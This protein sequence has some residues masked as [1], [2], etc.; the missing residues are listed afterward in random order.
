MSGVDNDNEV[1]EEEYS[2]AP[3]GQTGLPGHQGITRQ[4][5]NSSPLR[6]IREE[7]F[8]DTAGGG[9]DSFA[10]H[11]APPLQHSFPTQ[12]NIDPVR[13][14]AMS[15]S[16][17]SVGG[18]GGGG[19]ASTLFGAPPPSQPWADPTRRVAPVHVWRNKG[20][21]TL[22]AGTPPQGP[23]L[24][25]SLEGLRTLVDREPPAAALSPLTR[26]SGSSRMADHPHT[27]DVASSACYT[28]AGLLLGSSFRVGWGPGGVM[29]YPSNLGPSASCVVRASKVSLE[30]TVLAF[31]HPDQNV[32]LQ[33][34]SLDALRRRLR[35]SLEVHLEHS[36][37]DPSSKQ[38]LESSSN[39]VAPKWS[40]ECNAKTLPS[41]VSSF[42]SYADKEAACLSDPSA[43]KGQVATMTAAVLRHESESW[44]LIDALYGWIEGE[45]DSEVAPLR[46]ENENEDA[47]DEGIVAGVAG[48]SKS[49]LAGFKR[50]AAI[51]RWLRRQSLVLVESELSPSSLTPLDPSEAVLRLA[52]ANQ[53]NAAAAIAAAAGDVHL[54]T[55]LTQVGR[56]ALHLSLIGSN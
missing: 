9:L 31:S 8:A 22:T 16:F 13:M 33:E 45:D 21:G 35:A 3:P 51:T 41:L 37:L 48:E 2:L 54:A 52:C 19:G 14:M 15:Q 56:H 25:S 1:D 38:R 32:G 46:D 49:V 5:S 36:S 18:G 50:R 20:P 10:F 42:T 44:R 4:Q 12:L 30:G 29:A 53:A 17:L 7:Q 43:V 27:A 23:S 26:P 55:L 34:S 11:P 40:L 24:V 47:M 39:P 28:D 6:T